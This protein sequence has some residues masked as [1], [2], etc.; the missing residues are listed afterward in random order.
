LILFHTISVHLLVEEELQSFGTY[1][2]RRR[3]VSVRSRPPEC[4]NQKLCDP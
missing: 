1:C 2:T 3:S 4:Q